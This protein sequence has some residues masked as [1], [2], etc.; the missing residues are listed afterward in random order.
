MTGSDMFRTIV[1]KVQILALTRLVV[2]VLF[3]R[4]VCVPQLLSQREEQQP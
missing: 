2:V 1:C 4:P 3:T